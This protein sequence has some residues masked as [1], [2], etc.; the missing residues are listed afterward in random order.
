MRKVGSNKH[1]KSQ[2]A[3]RPSAERRTG[4][5]KLHT[6]EK[7]G[8]SVSFP[9]AQDCANVKSVAARQSSADAKITRPDRGAVHVGRNTGANTSSP[10]RDALE[11]AR[12]N[13]R[14]GAQIEAPRAFQKQLNHFGKPSR[15]TTVKTRTSRGNE[16]DFHLP[17]ADTVP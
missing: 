10:E 13:D 5:S 2:T 9:S 12:F 3:A 4:S 7:R 8:A 16:K 11:R 1:K 14:D 15:Q 17:V 6:P